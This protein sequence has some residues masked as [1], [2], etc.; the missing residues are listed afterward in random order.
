MILLNEKRIIFSIL[1]IIAVFACLASVYSSTTQEKPDNIITIENIEINTTAD[2]NITQF[3]LYNKTEENNCYNA[4]YVDEDFTGYNIWIWN[5]SEMD[6]SEWNDYVANWKTGYDN[7]PSETINGVVVYTISAER[8]D[9]VGQPR[10]DSYV[11]NQ[12]LK[13]IVEFAT[14]TQNETVKMKLSIE[15]N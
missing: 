6:N 3:I 8:G 4:Q 2:S 14:P 7:I 5:L 13:T 10:F 9:H 11:I 12:D 15:F 1:I